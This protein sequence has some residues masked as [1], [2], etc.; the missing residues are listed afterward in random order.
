MLY[1]FTL[2]IMGAVAYASLREGL[3]TSLSNLV[4]VVLAGLVAFNFF[5]PLSGELEKMVQGTFMENFEDGLALLILFAPILGLLRVLANNLANTDLEL[6]ALLQQIGSILVSLVTGYLAAGFLICAFQTLPLSENFLGFEYMNDAATPAYRR[7]M[8]PDR[9]W[10]SM[11]HH[12]GQ[13]PLSQE[14]SKTFDPEG[15]FE[16]RYGRL[17]RGKTTP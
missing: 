2:G 11:M 15:T 5:E 8:P 6:P 17:R 3:L 14:D 7:V 4:N 9:V 10:L 13:G 1:L 16:L 12:L